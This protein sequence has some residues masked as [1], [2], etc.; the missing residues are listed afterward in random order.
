[1]RIIALAAALIILT[2]FSPTGAH[3]AENNP[4]GVHTFIQDMMSDQMINVHLDWARSL[5][6]PGGYV[7]QL[8]YPVGPSTT[9][10][11]P[12]W[13]K[14][15]NGC[16]SRQLIPVI[17]LGTWIEN[18]SWVKPA[19]DSPG[20]YTTW[21]NAIKNIVSQMPRN[22]QIPL[23]IEILNECNNNMEW[24]GQANPTEYAQFF[25]QA[26]NAIRSLGD[27]RIKILNCGLSPGGSYNNVQFVAACCQV[28]GFI[29]AFDAWAC[30]PYPFYPPEINI[31]DGTASMGMF[32]IDS[33]LA[34]LQVLAQHGRPGVKIIATETGYGLGPEGEDVRADLTMR[35]FRDY[36]SKWPEVLGICPYE[37]CDPLGGNAGLDWVYPGSGT[38]AD[39]LPTSAH[40]QYWAVYKLAKPWS[41]TGTIS[42]K[43]TE[44]VFGAPL[45]GAQVTLDPGPTVNTDSAGNFCFDNLAPG[46]Y[47]LTVMKANYTNGSAT[48]IQVTAAKN[49]VRNFSLDPTTG[50]NIVGTVTDSIGGQPVQGV[51]VTLSPGNHITYTDATGKYQFLG[52]TPSTYSISASK[53]SYYN[54]RSPEMTLQAG[55]TKTLNFKMGPGS[56]PGGV[57]MIGGADFDY[58]PGT[59][60]AAG[61]IPEGGSGNHFYVDNSTCYS[62]L[63][64][65]KI[66]PYNT[67]ND[68]IWTMTDYSAV[69]SGSRYRIEVWCKTDSAISGAAKLIGNWYS[70]DMIWHGSM[71]GRPQLT[72]STG[73]TLLVARGMCPNMPS[74]NNRGRLQVE[75][76]AETSAGAVWFD[77]AWCGYDSQTE[78]PLPSI[79]NLNVTSTAL[80][81]HFAW[82]NSVGSN[83]TGTTIVYRTDRYPLHPADGTVLADVAGSPGSSML[84]VHT[85]LT[86][87]QRYY[88]A[89]FAHAA[90]GAYASRPAFA[91][92]VGTDTTR[93]S[94]PV[95]T[96]EGDYTF[97]PDTLS[98]TWSAIDPE[99]GIS[100]YRYCIGTT[101]GGSDV[102]D[103]SDAGTATGVNRS[104]LSL[105]PGQQYFFSVMALNGAGIWSY[106]G[107]SNGIYAVKDC[108]SI[109]EAKSLSDG[110]MVRISGAI[111]SAAGAFSGAAYIQD[112][113]KSAGIRIEGNIAS[114]V[115]GQQ[116]TV[117][118]TL[119]TRFGERYLTVQ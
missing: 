3:T 74:S 79:T 33:Y 94:T 60:A 39:K 75:L 101:S 30:H 10:I 64:S 21:A 8:M 48:N 2:A 32:T 35:A 68:M 54:F 38:T 114:M 116:V 76:R 18:G 17:R 31:H 53:Y 106:I 37:F 90:G 16:Y 117:I 78:E 99:S 88:Y 112:P 71:L 44:S 20:N 36:W 118:G 83:C 25:V 89:F 73:W 77:Q 7:K 109:S 28:P 119:G 108:A 11:N 63:C 62:G 5:T 104:G 52:V 111:I 41:T 6:G 86:L 81:A 102:L 50:C 22:D 27:P 34:E 105:V 67:S 100:N 95:V 13:I 47:S 107:K 40:G 92:T 93:P 24:S 4:Y 55:D 97:S 103:W 113:D 84:Y 46:N 58:T 65:Q 1:M 26:S 69:V 96:D 19:A 70:N 14:F 42:G 23:Y 80:R 57:N 85:G 51:Q 12:Q 29:D 87:G 98:A 72:T 110:A 82:V 61:W 66:G 115:E 9:T 59:G 49:E 43:V 91:T 15:I 56:P 45:S